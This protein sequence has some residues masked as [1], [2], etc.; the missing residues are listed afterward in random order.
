MK[1]RKF[2]LCN[3]AVAVPLESII[4]LG[5]VAT[6]LSVY[7][8]GISVL[9]QP[10]ESEEFDL[11]AKS[12]DICEALIKDPGQGVGSDVNWE[13]DP[14]NV[15]V[16]GLALAPT[17][18][19]FSYETVPSHTNVLYASSPSIGYRL[20]FGGQLVGYRRRN[21]S[22]ESCFLP[23]TKILMADGT[24]KNIEDIK[25]GDLVKAFDEKTGEIKTAKVT[26]V[27]H[28]SKEEMGD[29]YLVINGWL[30]VTPNHPIYAN[31]KWIEAGKLKVGDRLYGGEWVESIKEIFQREDTYNLELDKYHAYIVCSSHR[32]QIVA[33][34]AAIVREKY[35]P[36]PSWSSNGSD[37]GGDDGDGGD[38][39]FSP[40]TYGGSLTVAGGGGSS[41]TCLLAGTKILMADGTTKNIEDIKVGDLV[42]AFN[43]LTGKDDVAKVTKVFHHSREEMGDYYLVIDGWLRITPNHPLLVR[44]KWIYAGLLQEGQELPGYGKVK[45]IVKVYRKEESYNIELDKYH[46]FYVCDAKGKIILHNMLVPP[47]QPIYAA[48]FDAHEGGGL[49]HSYGI[50]IYYENGTIGYIITDPDVYKY[51]IL[52]MDKIMALKEMDYCKAKEAMGLDENYDFNITVTLLDGTNLL[53]YGKNI[54]DYQLSGKPV[55]T[56]Y[57]RDILVLD[58]ESGNI[59]SGTIKVTIVH[60]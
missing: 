20:T 55:I 34:N 47:K 38:D 4:A 2:I 35:G 44:G 45:S 24:T 46:A 5:V 23:G 1:N 6:M 39:Y 13:D 30:R 12:I 48:T 25:V 27:F 57:S 3:K 41:S 17:Y 40:L 22:G 50:V 51:G 29:Y 16:L 26:K 52:D 54:S 49:D 7:F 28:H 19:M 11:I 21:F 9:F 60:G 15:S 43:F 37:D 14:D 18:F 56:S 10:Y 32:D 33:H 42:K 36:Y 59:Y 8:L 31:G 58:R 53:S